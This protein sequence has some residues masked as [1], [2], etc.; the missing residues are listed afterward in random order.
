MLSRI[1]A[2]EGEEA[3][4]GELKLVF[5]AGSIEEL[6]PGSVGCCADNEEEAFCCCS[7]GALKYC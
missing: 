7:C 4:A 6:T 5:A 3:V 1:S 2:D